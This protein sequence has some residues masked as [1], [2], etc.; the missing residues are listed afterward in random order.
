M[1]VFDTLIYVALVSFVVSRV[2]LW[3]FERLG[4]GAPVA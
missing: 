1:F 3:A 2:A 4:D